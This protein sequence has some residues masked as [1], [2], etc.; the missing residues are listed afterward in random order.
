MPTP[1]DKIFNEITEDFNICQK[2]RNFAG[3]IGGSISIK[4]P[5]NCNRQYFNYK[6]SHSVVLQAVM[7][8]NLKFVTVDIGAYGKQSNSGVFQYSVSEFGNTKLGIT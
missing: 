4:C 5:P 7:D 8:G 6:Q 2:F 1:S 3:S